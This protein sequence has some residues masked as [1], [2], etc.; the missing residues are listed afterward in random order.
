MARVVH[1]VG[2]QMGKDEQVKQWRYL[3]VAATSWIGHSRL[4]Q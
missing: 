4:Q 3:F 1:T 2:V